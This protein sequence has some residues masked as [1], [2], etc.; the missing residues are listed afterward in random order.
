MNKICYTYYEPISEINNCKYRNY[1]QEKLIDICS[2]SWAKNGWEL[3]IL[4]HSIAEQNEFY[5]EYSSIVKSFPSVNPPLYD[6]HCYIRWLA[7][8][9]IGGGIMIDYD[10]M[11]VNLQSTHTNIFNTGKMTGFQKHVPSVVCGSAK[12]YI[13]VCRKFCQLKNNEDCI[14]DMNN[15]PHT[16]DM[17]M[18]STSFSLEYFQPLNYVVDYPNTGSLVHCSQRFCEINQKSKLEAMTEILNME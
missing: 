1:N 4:N 10:V 5:L 16:S 13:E 17:V 2:K 11:N 3:I 9:Q 12:Q 7:M 18:I 14:V 15:H 8:A 6:Y